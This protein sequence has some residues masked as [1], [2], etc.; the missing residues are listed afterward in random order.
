ML[1]GSNIII[2]IV[3]VYIVDLRI[4]NITREEGSP[5]ISQSSIVPVN[6]VIR[7]VAQAAPVKVFEKPKIR[8]GGKHVHESIR[9]WLPLI[10]KYSTEYGVD[11]DLVAAVLYVESKGDPYTVS[12]AGAMGLMQITPGTANHLGVEDVLDPEE[13]IRAGVKYLSWLINKYDEPSALLAYN[14]GLSMLERNRIPKETQKFVE[15]V[16][17]VRSFLQDSPKRDDLS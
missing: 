16:L 9:P 4:G 11:P 6:L 1:V 10:R 3:A 13:N 5:Q 2:F 12:P 17:S 14:A 7:E 8:T 15:K